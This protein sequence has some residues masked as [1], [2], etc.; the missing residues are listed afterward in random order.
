MDRTSTM[1]HRVIGCDL[2]R[3]W[4]DLHHLPDG[5][6]ERI[7]NTPEAIAAR[8]EALDPACLAAL[9]RE[10]REQARLLRAVPGIGPTVPATLLGELP[11]LGT[12]CRRRIAAL[13]R[14]ARE[15]GPWA[16]ARR[17]R[18]GGRKGREAPC[19]AARGASRRVPALIA[20]R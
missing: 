13:A 20:V 10:L 9:D 2:A 14:H 18:G 7:A 12:L 1:P 3:A 8:A 5:R 15:S 19:I 11:E 4:V 6:R 16:G 17:I